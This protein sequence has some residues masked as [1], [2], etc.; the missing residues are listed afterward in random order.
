MEAI[1]TLTNSGRAAD[2]GVASVAFPVAPP[3]R[4]CAAARPPIL[5]FAFVPSLLLLLL[6]LCVEFGL[7]IEP[8]IGRASVRAGRFLG[9]RVFIAEIAVASG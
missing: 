1:Q 2:G 9:S 3:L 6:L 5:F 4:F 7:R 8:H